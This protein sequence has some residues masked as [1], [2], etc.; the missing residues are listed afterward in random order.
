MDYGPNFGFRRFDETVS[1][2]EGRLKV[3]TSGTFRLG[4]LVTFD[5]AT[6]G[7][8]KAAA[9]DEV[10]VGG[11][12]GLLV[13]EEIWDRSIYAAP[14]VDSYYKGIAVNDRLAVIVS[15]AGT[16]VWFRNTALQNRADGRSIAAVT[17]VTLA[18]VVVGD[19]LK[20]TGSAWI[21]GLA[22]NSMLRVTSV[23]TNYCEAVL[24]Y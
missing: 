1:N 13:Q 15:G 23:A 14:D 4:S 7:Y 22:T 24:L 8:L 11:Y 10:A 16:K 12:G 21:E 17:M 19:Y 5:P 9:A 20:W 3:P 2:R 6:P 18:S